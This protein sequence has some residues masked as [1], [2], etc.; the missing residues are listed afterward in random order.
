V[1]SSDLPFNRYHVLRLWQAHGLAWDVSTPPR[2]VLH[3]G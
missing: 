2:S 1:L 3:A